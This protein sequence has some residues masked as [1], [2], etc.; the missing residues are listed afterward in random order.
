MI[1]SECGGYTLAVK[2]HLWNP[3]AKYG[4]GS[5]S[6]LL[7]TNEKLSSVRFCKTEKPY[8]NRRDSSIFALL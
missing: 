7:F 6:Y 3:K 1:I 4:Y 8:L 5:C 2:N